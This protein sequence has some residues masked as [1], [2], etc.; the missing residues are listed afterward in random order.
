LDHV[1]RE[2]LERPRRWGLSEIRNF[3][4][5]IG[6]LSSVF[7]FLTF[8]V[9][10]HMFRAG[11]ALFHTGWFVESLATQVLVIFVIR[12]RGNPLRSKP[13]AVLTMTSLA[14]VA[15][16]ALI[17]YTPFGARIGFVPMPG[18]FFLILPGMVLAYLALVQAANVR[19]Y[20]RLAVG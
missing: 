13:H 6:L 9:L 4:L 16:G 3:M 18:L 14:V 1:D 11:E 5:V 15:V 2:F 8:P 19:F 7:D 12:T 20:P 17:P 10:L